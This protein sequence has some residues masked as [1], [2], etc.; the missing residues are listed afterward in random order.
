MPRIGVV[1]GSTRP[2]RLSATVAASVVEQLSAYGEIDLIDL[3]EVGLPFYDEPKPAAAGEPVKLVEV[4]GVQLQFGG[5][6][7]VQGVW[8]PEASR[9][10]PARFTAM[11]ERLVGAIPAA[12]ATA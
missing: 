2:N 3:A 6:L 8:D 7:S 1:L 10:L 4:E 5:E 12:P 11:A 9:D